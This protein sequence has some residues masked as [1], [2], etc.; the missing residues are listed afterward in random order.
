M[1]FRATPI[2]LLLSGLL[3]V[4]HQWDALS[5]KT[6]FAPLS[7]L[8]TVGLCISGLF[9]AVW[10][11]KN[12]GAGQAADVCAASTDGSSALSPSRDEQAPVVCQESPSPPTPLGNADEQL[13]QVRT[14]VSTVRDNATKVNASSKARAAF[15]E[16]LVTMSKCL[17][18]DLEQINDSVADGK[19]ALVDIGGRLKGIS[20]QTARSLDRAN[21][22]SAAIDRVGESLTAF[23]DRFAEINATALSIS[24]V[25]EKT[26]LLALN[27]TIEAARA[28][29]AGQG[30]AVVASEVKL[31]AASAR[32][33]ADTINGLI[34]ALSKQVADVTDQFDHLRGDIATSVEEAENYQ[35]FQKVV[36]KSVSAV[37]DNVGHVSERVSDG[38]TIY[39][40]IVD[41][42][43]QI[44]GDAQTAIKGSARNMELTSEALLTLE[45]I[46][47][48]ARRP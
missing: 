21:E 28:G 37:T 32:Q 13:S 47:R 3:I 9:L 42:L 38:L 4:I 17:A 33:S 30:F 11:C 5:G 41:K 22:R 23:N 12:T 36:D 16:E 48:P 34:D 35:S 8:L 14:F 25:A 46:E 7:A 31:L 45:K 1:F 6:A 10:I 20:D 43:D 40:S 15:L 44:S 2:S 29:D 27:A 26:K 18:D 24:D 39:Q 19:G